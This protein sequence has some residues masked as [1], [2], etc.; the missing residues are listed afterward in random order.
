MKKIVAFIILIGLITGLSSCFKQMS[1]DDLLLAYQNDVEARNDIYTKYIEMYNQLSTQTIQSVVKVTKKVSLSLSSS[2]GSG[3]IFYED[4]SSYYILTNHHVVYNSSTNR[5]N[6]TVT[7]YLGKDHLATLLALDPSYDL[8]VLSMSKAKL[9]LKV[10]PFSKTDLSFKDMV[11]VMGYPNGQINAITLGEL[12]DY[13][14]ISISPE[15]ASIEVDFDVFIIDAPV[16]TGSSGSAL[17]NKDY[18]VVGIIY[19]GNF[20]NNNI[21]SKFAFSIPK[22]KIFEF[23]DLYGIAYQR[24]EQS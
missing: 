3:F 8:A 19:A 15:S 1:Y 5:A 24:G 2:V 14:Q 4:A 11:V 12:V 13:D 6:Y 7:D 16:E 18:E 10:L 21:T 20:L 23:L 17:I 9:A 22:V